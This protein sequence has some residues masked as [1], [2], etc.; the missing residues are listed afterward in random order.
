MPFLY[1][2][3]GTC[4]AGSHAFLDSTKPLQFDRAF[5]RSTDV[6]EACGSLQ[7]NFRAVSFILAAHFTM[8]LAA[9][10]VVE[11]PSAQ[12]SGRL[13][14]APCTPTSE[15]IDDHAS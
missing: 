1:A 14:L 12:N 10:T 2:V 15:I 9:S 13:R 6:T 11:Q 8:R 7:I 4:R 5:L 3:G